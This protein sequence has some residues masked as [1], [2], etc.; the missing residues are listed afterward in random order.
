VIAEP[1]LA[2]RFRAQA[3]IY[4]PVF[5][6]ITPLLLMLQG[7]AASQPDAAAMLAEIDQRRL[8]AAGKYAREAGATGQLASA[9]RSAETYCGPSLDGALWHQ[10]V[11]ERGWSD[12]RFA[13][14][15]G[16]LWISTLVLGA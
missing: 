15:L 12:D 10:L 9:R 14:W 5:R 13:A 1:D 3:A 4:P 6:R 16:Q 2:T 11:T 7:A 8:D